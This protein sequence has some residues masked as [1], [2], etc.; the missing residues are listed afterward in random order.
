MQYEHNGKDT[1]T[2]VSAIT[3]AP[4]WRSIITI[5]VLP[6]SAA[7][8]NMLNPPLYVA[9]TRNAHHTQTVALSKRSTTREPSMRTEAKM[10]APL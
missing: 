1:R 8:C 5:C 4:H 6:V 9:I 7:Q 3:S 10:H 2:S